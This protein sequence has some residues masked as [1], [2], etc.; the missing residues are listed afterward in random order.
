MHPDGMAIDVEDGI[1]VA[2]YGGGAVHRYDRDG[3]L[4]EVVEV[5]GASQVTA[6][7]FGG[8]DRRTLFITTSRENLGEDDEPDAGSLYRYE[9]GVTGAVPH[10]FAG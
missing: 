1:W 7:T 6:C 10:P 5:P 4:S 8:E 2:F 9:A 3:Q